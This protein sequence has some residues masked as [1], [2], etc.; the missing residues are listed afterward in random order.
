MPLQQ[1]D[2]DSKMKDIMIALKTTGGAELAVE[3]KKAIS[4]KLNN[5][6]NFMH[7]S[8]KKEIRNFE[9]RRKRFRVQGSR[10]DSRTS[11]N[12]T[13]PRSTSKTRKRQTF[14]KAQN[15]LCGII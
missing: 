9:G 5:Y 3:I 8:C 12:C 13:S 11:P 1:D 15:Q 6:A 4:E 7:G 2:M 10:T 14:N